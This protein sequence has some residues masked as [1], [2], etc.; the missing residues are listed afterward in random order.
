MLDKLK[1]KV[2]FALLQIEKIEIVINNHKNITNALNNIEGEAA[3]LMFLMQLGETLNK[4]LKINSELTVKFIEADD[5]KGA[6]AVRNFIAHDYE[7][8]DLAFIENIL[9]FKLSQLKQSL[10]Q[11]Q[12]F[13]KDEL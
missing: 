12:I 6:Y 2:D 8:V 10:K 1:A 7:G 4:I 13:L 5:I 3:I 11:Y 9:R